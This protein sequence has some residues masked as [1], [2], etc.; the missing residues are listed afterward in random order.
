MVTS[1]NA[2]VKVTVLC[3]RYPVASSC[4]YLWSVRH[5]EDYASTSFSSFSAASSGYCWRLR[6]PEPV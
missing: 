2:L 4:S 5:W 6:H 3:Y 1:K